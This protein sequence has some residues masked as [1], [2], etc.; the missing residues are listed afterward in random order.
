M[1]HLIVKDK[2]AEQH[3]SEKYSYCNSF[4]VTIDLLSGKNFKVAI[5]QL[6]NVQQV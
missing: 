4:G 6:S 5:T 3:I 1:Y 2:L